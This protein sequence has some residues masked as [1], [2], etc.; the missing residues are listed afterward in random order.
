MLSSSI[1]N[2]SVNADAS[3]YEDEHLRPLLLAQIRHSFLRAHNELSSIAQEIQLLSHAPNM[4]E[5]PSIRKSRDEREKQR[6]EDESAWRLE[7]L[8]LSVNGTDPHQLID[9]KGRILRPFTILP[10]SQSSNTLGTRLHL[11]SN[12]FGSSHRL[13]T[14]SIDE[15]LQLEQE[16]GNV[17]QGGGARNTEE[18]KREA[19]EKKAWE[20]EEDST[21]GYEREEAGLRKKREW[22]AYRDTHA[23]GEGNRMNRG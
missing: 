2:G 20:E 22:D 18:S 17:L 8:P 6:M 12:V 14:M 9:S 7:R 5:L 15:Y 1:S 21:H 13:P 16:R 23:K 19:E 11:Q 3:S 4:S 10:S